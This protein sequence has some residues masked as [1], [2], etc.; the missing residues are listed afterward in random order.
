MFYSISELPTSLSLR[1][2]GPKRNNCD[3]I[4][5]NIQNSTDNSN[6]CTFNQAWLG[7]W[8]SINHEQRLKN[9]SNHICYCLVY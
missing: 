7:L 1:Y 4:G 5:S 9:L 3:H 2:E 8:I 6:A